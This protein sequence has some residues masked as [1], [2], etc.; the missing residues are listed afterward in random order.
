[1]S[2]VKFHLLCTAAH[3]SYIIAMYHAKKFHIYAERQDYFKDKL[4]K[5]LES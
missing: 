2:H 5:L 4:D 3:I 1:M